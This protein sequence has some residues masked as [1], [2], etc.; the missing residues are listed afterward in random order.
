[1]EKE[2]SAWDSSNCY[3]YFHCILWVDRTPRNCMNA[4]LKTDKCSMNYRPSSVNKIQPFSDWSSIFTAIMQCYF[5]T[6][7]MHSAS[8]E[9]YL[10]KRRNSR[11][12]CMRLFLHRNKISSFPLLRLF[13]RL[14]FYFCNCSCSCVVVTL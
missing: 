13:K 1:M 3:R 14:K 8:L 4:I 6:H 7:Q 9:W 2:M 5:L 12:C 11:C 10:S